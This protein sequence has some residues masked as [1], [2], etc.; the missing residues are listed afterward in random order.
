VAWLYVG[1][2]EGCIS[3]VLQCN[4]ELAEVLLAN[5]F[6]VHCPNNWEH[7]T[8]HKDLRIGHLAGIT[9]RCRNERIMPAFTLLLTLEAKYKGI[10]QH[11]WGMLSMV[12][13]L[14]SRPWVSRML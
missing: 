9:I 14:A 5:T 11:M 3:E 13:V 6:N 1:D 4:P 10:N 12:C 8:T 7:Y 2:Y